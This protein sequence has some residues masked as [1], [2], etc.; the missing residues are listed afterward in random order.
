MNLQFVVPCC[1]DFIVSHTPSTTR[2]LLHKRKKQQLEI[3]KHGLT[4]SLVTRLQTNHL[5]A[6]NL[7]HPVSK[8]NGEGR[9]GQ[10]ERIPLE[11][12]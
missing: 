1:S 9:R 5:L 10:N 4:L 11:I 2:P 12:N 7:F 8:K 6:V 3:T